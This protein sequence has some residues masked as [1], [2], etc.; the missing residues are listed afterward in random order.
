MPSQENTHTQ[1]LHFDPKVHIAQC[2][3]VL[4]K[5]PDKS[6]R[7]KSFFGVGGKANKKIH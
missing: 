7:L 3:T 2:P 6:H 4:C 1:G 5:V